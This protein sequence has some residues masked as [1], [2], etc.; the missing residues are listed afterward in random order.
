M[1][2]M[3]RTPFVFDELSDEILASVENFRF[4]LNNP[5]LFGGG[6]RF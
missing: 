5:D 2:K 3:E 6:N 1:S 4:S